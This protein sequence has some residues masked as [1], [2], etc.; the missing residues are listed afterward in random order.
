[1][2]KTKISNDLTCWYGMMIY[3]TQ[4]WNTK[5]E[6]SWDQRWGKILCHQYLIMPITEYQNNVIQ[7]NMKYSSSS[8]LQEYQGYHFHRC[9]LFLQNA[10]WKNDRAQNYLLHNIIPTL[11]LNQKLAYNTS[12]N[13]L[14]WTYDEFCFSKFEVAVLRKECHSTTFLHSSQQTY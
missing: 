7:W 4:G 14:V 13:G 8:R 9:Y 12:I 1:M 6:R 3:R 5:G 2:T 10:A 11:C